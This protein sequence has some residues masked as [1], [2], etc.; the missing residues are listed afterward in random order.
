MEGFW[1]MGFT[2]RDLDVSIAFYRD[3]LRMQVDEVMELA[4]ERF[5]TLTANPGARTRL[6]FMSKPVAGT[7]STVGPHTGRSRCSCGS[8]TK[9]VG[10]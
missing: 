8:T 6:C 10:K 4:T 5:G 1:H 3:V 2:V 7:G 9:A